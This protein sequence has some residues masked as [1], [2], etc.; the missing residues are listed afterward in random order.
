MP[1]RENTS[2]ETPPESEE[3]HLVE[4]TGASLSSSGTT[5]YENTLLGYSFE[6]PRGA[7]Y[8]GFGARDGAS[9]SVAITTGTG[10]ETWTG[11][12]VRVW[13]FPNT[14]LPEFSEVE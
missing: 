14:I 9:H 7:Y 5:K 3:A 12:L 6:I 10:V 4:Q 11:A 2:P 8:A 13:Y 1:S